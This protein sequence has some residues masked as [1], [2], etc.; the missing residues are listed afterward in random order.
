MRKYFFFI[1]CILQ[2]RDRDR[3]RTE[4]RA[5]ASEGPP[6]IPFADVVASLNFVRS[7]RNYFHLRSN[8]ERLELV[9][10][11]IYGDGLDSREKRKHRASS[12]FLTRRFFEA[13]EKRRKTAG[14]ELDVPACVWARTVALRLDEPAVVARL[15]EL[16][17]VRAAVRAAQLPVP[18]VVVVRLAVVVPRLG[19][20]VPR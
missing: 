6:S 9:G 3:R 20:I 14:P 4:P 1:I 18:E 2:R 16:L 19:Q 10:P 12:F 17:A 11:E 13:S 8:L 7:N 15:V 5:A